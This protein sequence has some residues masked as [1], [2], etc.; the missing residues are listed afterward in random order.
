M[1]DDMEFYKEMVG[2]YRRAKEEVNY[3]ATRFI[4]MV[5]ERGGVETAKILVNANTPSDGYTELWQRNRL[6]LTVEA[7]MIKEEWSSLFTPQELERARAR[8]EEYGYV[9]P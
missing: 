4:Q 2:I 6:D 8:L 7:L 3:T 1:P 5:A 9:L